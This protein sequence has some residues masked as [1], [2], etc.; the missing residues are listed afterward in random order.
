M[1]D[2]EDPTSGA[3]PAGLLPPDAYLAWRFVDA[4][5]EIDRRQIYYDDGRVELVEGVER[6]ELCRFTTEQVAAA[7]AGV[8]DS[9]LAEAAAGEDVVH[10]AG[11]VTYAWRVDGR[12][13]SFTDRSS[14]RSPHPAIAR[15]DADLAPLEEAAGGWPLLADE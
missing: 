5:R 1:S 9:G 12:E 7:R 13:G 8:L 11:P 14:Q 4:L 15:L 6:R 3:G 10:D 2:Q